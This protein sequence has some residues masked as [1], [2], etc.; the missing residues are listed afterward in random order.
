[1]S[2]TPAPKPRSI[3]GTRRPSPRGKVRA[4]ADAA[5]RADGPPDFAGL[6]ALRSPRPLAEDAADVLRTQILAGGL[7]RGA[8]LVEA[9]I[10]R[11]FNVS[12]GPVR[13]AFKL[14]R[15][16]GLVEEEP[17]RGTFVVTLSSVDVREIYDLRAALEGRAARSIAR[18]RDPAALDELRTTLDA[19]AAAAAAGDV[20]E[21][22]RQDLQFH[23]SI[24]RLSG[25]ARLHSTFQR[26]V[27][28]LQTLIK[29]DEYLYRS[30]SEIATQH[31]PILSALGVGDADGAA[32]AC[33][34][35]CDDARDL[36]ADYIDRLPAR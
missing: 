11:Q 25:N 32:A 20:R 34:A 6:P 19:I 23:D 21:V 29:L 22:A 2:L 24:C 28:A 17:R 26:H 12:R 5:R 35:H 33:E 10:A 8:H 30:M 3:A 13:E 18:R 16:E 7:P 9:R 1:M 27:P 4:G 15:A 36:V 31:E 14:L